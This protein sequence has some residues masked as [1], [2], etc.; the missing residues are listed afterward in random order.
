MC[1]G[2]QLGPL[3]YLQRVEEAPSELGSSTHLQSVK[4]RTESPPSFSG[5]LGQDPVLLSFLICL[6]LL[7]GAPN[8]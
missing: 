3:P 6:L 1:L 4:L 8:L 7:L 5:C 2:P